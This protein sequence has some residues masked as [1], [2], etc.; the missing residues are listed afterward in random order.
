MSGPYLDFG[1]KLVAWTQH[2]IAAA[3]NRYPGY[4][5]H[6]YGFLLSSR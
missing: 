1:P 3:D 2:M 6:E 4:R 5:I